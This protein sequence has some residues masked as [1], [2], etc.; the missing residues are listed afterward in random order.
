M[1]LTG[2]APGPLLWHSLCLVADRT[3]LVFGGK[4]RARD[5]AST[6]GVHVADMET[7]KW[8]EPFDAP[9]SSVRH[10]SLPVPN[11]A[12]ASPTA[13]GPG[14]RSGHAAVAV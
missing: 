8:E 14:A 3:L 6:A 7:A 11:V 12:S 1:P 10:A 4:R 9:G 13:D 5:T 2:A